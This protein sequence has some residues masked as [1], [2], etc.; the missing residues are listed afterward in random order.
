VAARTVDFL[1]DLRR[2]TGIAEIFTLPID[3]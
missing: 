3:E 2:P 1:R